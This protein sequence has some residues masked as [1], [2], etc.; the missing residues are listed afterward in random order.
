M[1]AI[2]SP[3]QWTSY[4][5][6]SQGHKVRGAGRPGLGEARAT[7]PRPVRVAAGQVL[8]TTST[9][10]PVSCKQ[11]T[12]GCASFDL[13]HLHFRIGH[14]VITLGA[15]R[16]GRSTTRVTRLSPARSVEAWATGGNSTTRQPHA[17]KQVILGLCQLTLTGPAA[18]DVV[19]PRVI[20]S[21]GQGQVAQVGVEPRSRS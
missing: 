21:G 13:P 6:R 12:W 1:P 7:R 4:S 14:K 10:Q 8:S 2:S 11:G 17:R 5:P 9:R 16:P 20:R 3:Q 15:G 18:M 19:L